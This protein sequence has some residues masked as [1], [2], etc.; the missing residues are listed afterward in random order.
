MN[1]AT[2]ALS[3]GCIQISDRIKAEVHDMSHTPQTFTRVTEVSPL[4]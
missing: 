1:L 4:Q 2:A 3:Y